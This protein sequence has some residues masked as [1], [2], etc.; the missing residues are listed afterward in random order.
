[1]DPNEA[2]R[3]GL[4]F[5]AQAIPFVTDVTACAEL[6]VASEL[7]GSRPISVMLISAGYGAL[8][9]EPLRKE[10]AKRDV[11]YLVTMQENGQRPD[12]DAIDMVQHGV[13]LL[14]SL[15]T[16]SLADIL[17]RL[18]LDQTV[19][20]VK[21]L[22]RMLR[23]PSAPVPVGPF[24]Q[25]TLTPREFEVLSFLAEGLSNKQIA[26]RISISEHGVKRHVANVLAKLNCPNRT[27]AVSYA[28]QVGI[29]E[30]AAPRESAARQLG[31]VRHSRAS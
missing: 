3:T 11:K 22:Q 12:R 1:M 25:P 31:P 21:L 8:P 26:R 24:S 28:L 18:A 16:S 4:A 6:D 7:I 9:T 15:T 2:I 13:I 19:L 10:A 27:Q 23:N 20:P 29:L 5:M 30:S 17:H 14:E